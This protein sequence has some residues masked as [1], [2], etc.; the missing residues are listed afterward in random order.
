LSAPGGAAPTER[1]AGTAS[2]DPAPAAS[3]ARQAR[4]AVLAL[5]LDPLCVDGAQM[6]GLTAPLVRAFIEAQLERVRNA[7]YDV[8]SCLVDTGATA[9]AALERSL[10][11]KR[12]DV[13]MIGAGLR[14]PVHLLLFERLVNT[15]HRR[16]PVARLC[17]NTQPGDT[18][19]AVR[20]GLD[21]G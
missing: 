1:G 8:D 5:G 20:R 3:V 18:L 19:E 21:P 16:A 13:V 9:Q 12:F 6:R 2:G 10:A 11:A 4:P 17:F 7:G 14:D 15:I